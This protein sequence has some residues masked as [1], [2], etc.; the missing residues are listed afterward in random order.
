MHP[1]IYLGEENWNFKAGPISM[2]NVHLCKSSSSK[3]NFPIVNDFSSWNRFLIHK[4]MLLILVFSRIWNVCVNIIPLFH[5]H[6]KWTFVKLNELGHRNCYLMSLMSFWIWIS[7]FFC[8]RTQMLST[9]TKVFNV[10]CDRLLKSLVGSKSQTLLI[11]NR[12][13]SN[14]VDLEIIL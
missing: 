7:H 4:N 14:H 11:L 3:D 10:K 12:L 8:F 1:F 2:S 13:F 6:T 9:K 5:M